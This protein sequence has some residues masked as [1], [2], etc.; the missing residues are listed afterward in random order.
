MNETNY[1]TEEALP[2]ELYRRGMW[3]L[4]ILGATTT[5]IF[6]AWLA[7][8]RA[9]I[10]TARRETR[11]AEER[12]NEVQRER[13][14]ALRERIDTTKRLTDM[15]AKTEAARLAA[16]RKLRELEER[17]ISSGAASPAQA[18]LAPNPNLQPRTVSSGPKAEELT[19][20]IKAH[21][22]HMTE[23]VES[24]LPDYAADVDFHD[25]PHA[26]IQA[27][28][29]DRKQW[30]L[31]YPT[32]VIFTDEIQPQFSAIRDAGFGWIATATFTWRWAFRSRTGATMRGMTRDTWKI[33]PSN[34]G[35]RIVAEHSADP[36]TG[37]SKD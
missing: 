23:A 15:V 31:R 35:F 29:N 5:F 33:V 36:V 2:P 25:K 8:Q 21:L 10:V 34:G 14:D 30:A 18:A 19:A 9:E 22:I 12:N 32:R 17:A 27:I 4:T 16:E 3:A 11:E 20:F 13:D 26:S 6:F 1:L 24:E 7:I 37:Q 28:E